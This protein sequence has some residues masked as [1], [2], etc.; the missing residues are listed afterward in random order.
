MTWIICFI[1]RTQLIYAYSL[2][3]AYSNSLREAR[4]ILN[5]INQT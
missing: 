5:A 4:K 3:D 1:I 2:F